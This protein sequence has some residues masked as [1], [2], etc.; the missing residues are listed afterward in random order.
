MKKS[1][2]EFLLLFIRLLKWECRWRGHEGSTCFTPV[3]VEGSLFTK[4]AT[5]EYAHAKWLD[6][7]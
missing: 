7:D 5:A 2:T 6:A 3:R 1:Q 4:L